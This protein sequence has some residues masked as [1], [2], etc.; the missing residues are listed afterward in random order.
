MSSVSD[1][2][3]SSDWSFV[4]V[5]PNRSQSLF[6]IFS[7]FPIIH[8]FCGWLIIQ[9]QRDFSITL[10]NYYSK[11]PNYCS[12]KRKSCVFSNLRHFSQEKY[13]EVC[14]MATHRHVSFS[15]NSTSKS[16]AAYLPTFSPR[17]H[18]YGLLQSAAAKPMKIQWVGF[19]ILISSEKTFQPFC[20]L[21]LVGRF[22]LFSIGRWTKL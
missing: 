7:R 20:K 5:T 14:L 6:A 22:L 16:R 21:L 4:A 18:L 3:Y 13:C 9:L 2:E 11:L 8:Q 19:S 12:Q 1:D 10:Q 17:L 15:S